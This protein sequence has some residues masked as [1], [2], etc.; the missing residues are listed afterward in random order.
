MIFAERPLECKKEHKI[1]NFSQS[2]QE[3]KI[4][5]IQKLIPI[6]F[7]DILFLQA[8]LSKDLKSTKKTRG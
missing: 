4:F 7:T 3:K 5:S 8:W 2:Q 6:F 1:L